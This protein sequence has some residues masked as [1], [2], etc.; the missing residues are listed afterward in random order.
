MKI[1]RLSTPH[2]DIKIKIRQN[3]R[4]DNEVAGLKPMYIR[5]NMLIYDYSEEN[6]F[7]GGNEFRYFNTKNERFTGESI[8]EIS[9][10]RPYYHFTLLPD[11]VR[12]GKGY[13]YYKDLNGQFYIDREHVRDPLVEADYVMVHFTL[14]LEEPLLGG[15]VYVYGE[16]SGRECKLRNRMQYNVEHKQYELTMLLKQGFYA[17]QYAYV[18]G[19][20]KS[21]NLKN[22][23]GSFYET[24]N[25]YQIFI[26]HQ[27]ISSRHE[28]LI[29]YA[30]LNSMRDRRF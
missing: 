17:Y 6:V 28:Q 23:E 21:Y 16:L 10:F 11:Q 22:I 20:S 18:S 1:I 2:D 9:Y 29:G 14:P 5:E 19:D 27:P 8:E 13:G 15:Y 3:N 26:Y 12:R 25:D 7:P 4:E 30:R 24:E